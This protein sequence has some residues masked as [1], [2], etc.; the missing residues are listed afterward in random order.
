[1]SGQVDEILA[2][3]RAL[4]KRL[5]ERRSMRS[6][7]VDAARSGKKPIIGEVK[8]KGL[9]EGEIAIAVDASEAARRIE[10]GGACAVSVLTEEAFNG[11]LADLRAVKMAVSIPV[12]RKDFIF[13]EFQIMESYVHGAD[14]ILLIVRYL[15]ER[16][17]IELVRAAARIG[18]E[19]LVE[20][21]RVSRDKLPL[22]ELSEV[23]ESVLL[24]INNRDLHTLDVN[25]ETFE[26][27][28]PEVIPE[29]PDGVPLIAMSGIETRADAER[30]FNAGASAILVGTSVMH[31]P[32][33]SD[34]VRE[35]VVCGGG[36][37]W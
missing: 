35:F 23:S 32:D 16:Q 5:K 10:E 12:L 13:D 29:I 18:L 26:T 37:R 8:R 11:S 21:D 34:K 22:H 19:S 31:S 17:V 6:A 20:I 15:S 24:G 36:L 9:K 2:R 4:L 33:M 14:A 28:A 27:L 1:M 7:I 3:K 25:I 30:M